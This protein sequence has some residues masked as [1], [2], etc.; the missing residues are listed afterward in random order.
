MNPDN[1]RLVGSLLIK[2]EA[3]LLIMRVFL[4]QDYADE[5]S[6]C[7]SKRSSTISVKTALAKN[8]VLSTR[9]YG[10]SFVSPGGWSRFVNTNVNGGLECLL[11]RLST[12]LRR[13]RFLFGFLSKLEEV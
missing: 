8:P 11:I 9:I 6:N 13:Y 10:G 1:E 7:L 4:R 12:Y 3:A 2:P 5:T